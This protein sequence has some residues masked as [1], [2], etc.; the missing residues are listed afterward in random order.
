MSGYVNNGLLPTGPA[1][2]DLSGSF[3]SPIV[4][5]I[6][7]NPVDPRTPQNGLAKWTIFKNS[8]IPNTY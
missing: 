4:N 5:N 7:T 6:Q 1:G 8:T 3:P 2:G